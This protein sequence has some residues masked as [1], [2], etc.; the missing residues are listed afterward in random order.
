VLVEA[1]L[2]ALRAVREPTVA[3]IGTGSGAI[4]VTVAV[5]RPD[6]LVIATDLSAGA[7]AVA[8]TN[9]DAHGV[10]DRIRFLEGDLVAPV[11][12][13]G[14]ACDLVA[15]NPPYVA[16]EAAAGLPREIREHEPRLAIVAPEGGER[17]HAR[18]VREAPPV[19]RPGG[20]LMMEVAAGQAG[21]VVELVRQSGLYDTPHVRRD[22]LG[23]ERVVAARVRTSPL[24]EA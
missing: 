8:R 16:P 3:D 22:G 18:L 9:A 11:R 20:W 19:L 10:T 24:T 23:W 17:L 14:V 12:A 7:L 15:S 13:A 1:V 6:A 5:R 2:D 21:R 4:A